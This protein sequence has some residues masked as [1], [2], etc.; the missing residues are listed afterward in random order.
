MA[1]NPFVGSWR[2]V[3]YTNEDEDGN[4]THPFGEDAHGYIMYGTDG[5]MQVALMTAGRPIFPTE[6]FRSGST[7]DKAASFDGYISYAG[8]Y[9]IGEDIITHHVEVAWFPNMV[10]KDNVRAY[11]F[12]GDR[13][14]LSV[15]PVEVDGVEVTGH[16]IWEKV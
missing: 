5:Y 7:E 10:G 8:P 1:E 3:S 2:F 12:D 9:T 13:L 16:L 15:P 6:R 14:R 4:I 11:K